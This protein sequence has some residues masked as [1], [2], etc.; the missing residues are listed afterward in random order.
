PPAWLEAVMAD[1]DAFLL[2][3]A[4]CERK[5]SATAMALI[6]HYPDRTELVRA[7]LALAREELE[8]FERVWE[9]VTERG[10]TLGSDTRNPYVERLAR[11]YRK[12]GEAY[13]LDRLLVTAIVEARGCERFGLLAA[14]LPS[15]AMRDFYRELARSEVRHHETYLELAGRYFGPEAVQARL[16]E[17]LEV[18]S[19]IVRELPARAAMY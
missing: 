4:A 6:A 16:A 10:R 2:D 7:C 18:E 17:L 1:F 5:A 12:G 14:A 15:G 19:R 11:E 13:F 9:L 8:H 3:H